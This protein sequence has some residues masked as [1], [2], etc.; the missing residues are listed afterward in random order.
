LIKALL[1][2]FG[3]SSYNLIPIRLANFVKTFGLDIE[4]KQ[5][6]PHAFNV[7]EN[8]ENALDHLPDKHFYGPDSMMPSE[9]E[10]FELWWEENKDEPFSLK[11]TLAEY[12]NNGRFT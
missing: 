6:F 7:A 12:C 4:T 1:Y 9:R 10:E 2:L 5:H 8:F 3:T 11:D